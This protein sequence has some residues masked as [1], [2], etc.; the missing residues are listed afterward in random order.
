MYF[1]PPFQRLKY[2][3]ANFHET[4]DEM[5]SIGAELNAVLD[6]SNT[7]CPFFC[8]ISLFDYVV[9]FIFRPC[10]P[11]SRTSYKVPWML[12]YLISFFT[13]ADVS[14]KYIRCLFL[15]YHPS[16]NF[17]QVPG[18]GLKIQFDRWG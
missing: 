2:Q 18:T 5:Y 14:V 8:F 13:V 9:R 3:L 16:N 7:V 17:T 4:L 12:N 1:H 10:T 6:L 11:Y 15:F